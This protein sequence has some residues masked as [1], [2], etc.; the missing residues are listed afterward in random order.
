MM[1]KHE[2]L[3]IIASTSMKGYGNY[4]REKNKS[5]QNYFP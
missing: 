5:K 3:N 4:L 2:I 1:S